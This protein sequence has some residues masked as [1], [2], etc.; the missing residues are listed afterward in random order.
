MQIILYMGARGDQIDL[1]VN[2]S[3]FPPPVPSGVLAPQFKFAATDFW[4]QGLQLG[5][6]Y[7]Y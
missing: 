6:D 1:H 5:L 2:P 7:R 3:L 4:A